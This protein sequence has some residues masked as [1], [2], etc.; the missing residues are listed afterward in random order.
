MSDLRLKPFA[1][2]N[3]LPAC[4]E[5]AP[6]HGRPGISHLARNN[7]PTSSVLD[8]E[9]DPLRAGSS[10]YMARIQEG[11]WHRQVIGVR[12]IRVEHMSAPNDHW[13]HTITDCA[14]Q[15]RFTREL[16]LES[17]IISNLRHS[18]TA[19][20]ERMT[21]LSSKAALDAFSETLAQELEVVPF[22]VRV[23]V[24]APGVFL[25][26]FPAAIAAITGLARTRLRRPSR[27]S[28][29]D[30]KQLAERLCEIVSGTG[31]AQGLMDHNDWVRVPLGPDWGKAVAISASVEAYEPIWKSTNMDDTR[32]KEVLDSNS[33]TN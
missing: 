25:T 19:G 17:R 28:I 32:L 4:G 15:N 14:P 10:Q 18:P 3:F 7:S 8:E 21:S 30:P 23:H 16:K 6:F 9:R 11:L 20:V 26:N 33:L 22:G 13:P 24:I 29:G 27:D 2:S 31:L 1:P 12:V 5:F